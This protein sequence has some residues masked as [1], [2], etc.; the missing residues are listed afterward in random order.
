LEIGEEGTAEKPD[1][2]KILSTDDEKIQSFGELLTNESSREILQLLFHEE[3]SASQIAQKT[4]VSVQ[5]LKYHINKM[6][7]LGVVKVSKVEKTSKGQDLKF[8]RA[9]KFAIVIVPSHVSKKAK[10][11]K[12]LV[13]S[14]KT[15]YRFA[16]IG[17]AAILSGVATFAVQ[18]GNDDT[19]RGGF[20]ELEG[21]SG[22]ESALPVIVPLV[23]ISIGLG[24]ELYLRRVN[25]LEKKI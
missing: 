9:K 21:A 5:L 22:V 18:S 16:A 19:S 12:L 11:S 13:R 17:A 23:I 2:I 3:L 25:K 4:N 20:D 7:D 14:F 24:I 8:Y 6:L 1:E 15:I 10:E